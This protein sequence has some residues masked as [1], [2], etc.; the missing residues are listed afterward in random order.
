MF[1]AGELKK[2][3]ECGQL[4]ELLSAIRHLSQDAHAIAGRLLDQRTCDEIDAMRETANRIIG[5]VMSESDMIREGL[6]DD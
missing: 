2:L 1:D 5:Q 6:G 4:Y 3:I